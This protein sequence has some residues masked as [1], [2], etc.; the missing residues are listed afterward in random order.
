MFSV[1]VVGKDQSLTLDACFAS[2]RGAGELIYVDLGS[3]DHSCELARAHGAKVLRGTAGG[4]IARNEAALSAKFDWALWLSPDDVLEEDGAGKIRAA[5]CEAEN[6]DAFN[7]RILERNFPNHAFKFPRVFRTSCKWIGSTHEY[8]EAK[9][10]VD[11]DVSVTHT[12]GPWHDKPSDP[13]AV[14]RA[15]WSDLQADMKHPR[16]LYYYAREYFYRRDWITAAYWFEKRTQVVGYTPEL[17]DA[18]LYLARCYWLLNE[19]DKARAACALA[20][21]VNV[22]FKEALLFMAEITAESNA[23]RWKEIADAATNKGVLF[24]R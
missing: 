10:T 9:N 18:Y 4:A 22:Q 14:M 21:V 20:V 3:E 23:P 1:V 7:L 16:W 11:L 17:A 6:I 2:L 19:G 15:L 5:I 8:L 13:D 24:V 12:R